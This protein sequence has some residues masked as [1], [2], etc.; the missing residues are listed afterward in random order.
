[1]RTPCRTLVVAMW[2]ALAVGGTVH[3]Q[4]RGAPPPEKGSTGPTVPDT[5]PVELGELGVT[6]MPSATPAPDVPG[7]GQHGRAGE[8]FGAG[9]GAPNRPADKP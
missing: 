3:A 8:G 6:T 5:R 2:T 1:M 4:S 7:T 9:M